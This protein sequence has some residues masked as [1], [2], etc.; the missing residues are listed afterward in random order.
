MKNAI[1]VKEDNK[2]IIEKQLHLVQDSCKTNIVAYISIINVIDYIN[3]RFHM[4]TN[5][6]K[7]GLSLKCDIFASLYSKSCKYIPEST[8]FDLTFEKGSWR[9]D[10]I[11]RETQ[12]KHSNICFRLLKISDLAKDKLIEKHCNW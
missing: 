8:Q 4:L 12:K 9:I 5:K 10:N 6:E 3:K 11:R 7:D 1:I 2:D